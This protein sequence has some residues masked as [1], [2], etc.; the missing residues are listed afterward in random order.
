MAKIGYN[1]K[2]LSDFGG[3]INTLLWDT[4]IDENQSIESNNFWVEGNKLA[5]IKWFLRKTKVGTNNKKIQW[6]TNY[7]DYIIAIHD[8]KLYVYNKTNWVTTS[9]TITW[10]N[11][12]DD[13]NITV[14][15]YANIYIII[16]SRSW[17]FVP[18]SFKFVE[19]W[20]TLSD[21]SSNFVWLAWT[22][23]PT[24]SI[25][26]DWQL[27]FWGSAW[28]PS[29][30]LY[31]KVYN[32]WATPEWYDFSAYKSWSQIVG[33]WSPIVWFV[34]GKDN[35][36]IAKRNSIWKIDS[37]YD[38]TTDWIFWY[39]VSKETS[40]WPV[41]QESIINVLQDI[42]YFDWDSV[43]RLS[44][45]ASTLALKDTAISANI[46]P[47]FQAIQRDQSKSTMW[48]SY[49][50]VKIWVRTSIS[51]DND[52]VFTYNLINKSWATQ[53]WYSV[54]HSTSWYFEN[55]ISYFGGWFDWTIY[56]DNYSYSFNDWDVDKSYT[57]R[58][59][60]F[61]DDVDYKRVWEVE[62]A[63]RVE[64]WHTYYI[65]ILKGSQVIATRTIY[66]DSSILPTIGSETI[67]VVT[68]WASTSSNDKLIDFRERI[69]LFDD[70]RVFYWRLRGQNTWYIEI[71][72]VNW[73]SKFV[74]AYD[75]HY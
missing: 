23:K 54:T 35:T 53:T 65:D 47:S 46:L 72:A 24:C 66:E 2:R 43:R 22:F 69:E 11:A 9:A 50:Y 30:L 16:T 75:I 4:D 40:T 26:L 38:N 58:W 56:E 64:A 12:T 8:G 60:N 41:N 15:K 28:S 44:Y 55:S 25:F 45:E 18:Y 10:I 13:F 1:T 17:S 61:G 59:M 71:Q 51:S 48:M 73:M 68:P 7:W 37:A 57:S 49:P 62:I 3:G 52:L 14:G 21:D 70:W 39:K 19:T 20:P 36:F 5:P 67:W 33:D 31:S 32:L 42:F 63:W 34:T 27:L 6:L 74:K 29:Q